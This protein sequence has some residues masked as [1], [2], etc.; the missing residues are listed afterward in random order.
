MS[1]DPSVLCQ[2]LQVALMSHP[3]VRFWGDNQL[4]ET[5]GLSA[6][7]EGAPATD[8]QLVTGASGFFL[9]LSESDSDLEP[10]GAGIQHLQKLSQELDAAIVAEER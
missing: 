9:L 6:G 10:V 7:L 4:P 1:L 5:P 8:F 3:G 2:L